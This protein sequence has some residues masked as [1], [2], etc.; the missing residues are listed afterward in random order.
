MPERP[1]GEN[2]GG[3]GGIRMSCFFP[4]LNHIIQRHTYRN[5]AIPSYRHAKFVL[6]LELT[7]AGEDV[8]GPNIPMNDHALVQDF[9]R[10]HDL[11]NALL[12]VEFLH[13]RLRSG[14]HTGQPPFVA[15]TA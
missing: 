12:A 7:V 13:Q 10:R 15:A 9:Y 8:C 5:N 2:T 3:G 4:V 14:S 6:D 1:T 11:S